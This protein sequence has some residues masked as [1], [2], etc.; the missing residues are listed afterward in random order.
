MELLL[1]TSH[2][3]HGLARQ[4]GYWLSVKQRVLMCAVGHGGWLRLPGT[5][6]RNSAT[7]PSWVRNVGFEFPPL[8]QEVPNLNLQ[9]L[10]PEYNSSA[11]PIA[12]A[13]MAGNLRLELHHE[14]RSNDGGA[15]TQKT[16][17]C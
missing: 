13:S 4:V 12:P 9:E 6:F 15:E 16:T 8:P 11:S 2:L 10:F 5:S 3:A 17:S 14:K 7:T 1:R